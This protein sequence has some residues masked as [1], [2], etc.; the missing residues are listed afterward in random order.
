[1]DE[2]GL[3]HVCRVQTSSSHVYWLRVRVRN[4][5]AHRFHQ[6][7]DLKLRGKKGKR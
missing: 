7:Q 2:D 4:S 6:G 5:E 1:M 3:V